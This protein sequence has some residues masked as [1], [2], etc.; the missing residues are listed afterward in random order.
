V[1]LIESLCWAELN[2]ARLRAVVAERN[3]GNFQLCSQ[4]YSPRPGDHS[5]TMCVLGEQTR[6]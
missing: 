2:T 4:A 6:G 3:R 5:A 1:D